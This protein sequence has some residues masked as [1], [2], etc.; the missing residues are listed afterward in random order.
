M[1]LIYRRGPSSAAFSCFQ[2]TLKLQKRSAKAP[3]RLGLG[4]LA[5]L[6]PHNMRLGPTNIIEG[7]LFGC[8]V[9]S[10][11]VLTL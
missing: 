3:Q 9:I 5:T 2:F 1:Q 6:N 7:G 4:N 11:G 10:P 8:C